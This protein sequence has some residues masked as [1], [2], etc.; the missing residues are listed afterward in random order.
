MN[1][2]DDHLLGS[3]SILGAAGITGPR[4]L[5]IRAGQIPHEQAMMLQ[6]IQD[7]AVQD[8]ALRRTSEHSEGDTARI[9]SSASELARERGAVQLRARAA[10]VP[11]EW[12]GR[13]TQLGQNGIGWGEDQVLPNPI[14]LSQRRSIHRIARDTRHLVNM[15]AIAVVREHQVDRLGALLAPDPMIAVQYSRIM[16]ALWRRATH[17]GHTITIS[18]RARERAWGIDEK[19]VTGRVRG[20]LHL[21]PAEIDM[22]WQH[23]AAP[24][25][26]DRLRSSLRE[27]RHAAPQAD[28][29]PRSSAPVPEQFLAVARKA[30]DAVLADQPSP[31]IGAAITDVLPEIEV[32]RAWET[33]TDPT[34]GSHTGPDIASDVHQYLEGGP[35]P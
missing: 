15:A 17:T 26:A 11:V 22:L 30:L 4:E 5:V 33:G 3:S 6:Q 7:L 35:D 31:V 32:T 12:I 1:T 21:K 2:P 14:T 20:L 13:V 24:G 28:T 29:D 8:A 23:Y 27:L 25:L 19:T 10:G 34:H 9:A 18:D 16:Q